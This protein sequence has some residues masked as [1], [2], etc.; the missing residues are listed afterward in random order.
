MLSPK[1]TSF[2]L[3]LQLALTAIGCSSLQPEPSQQLNPNP[4]EATFF[5][6]GLFDADLSSKLYSYPEKFVIKPAGGVTVNKMP[7]RLDKWLSMIKQENG[8]VQLKEYS[9]GS[10]KDIGLLV[11]MAVQLFDLAKEAAT[12]RPA[13]KYDA[14]VEYDKSTG[15]VRQITFYK[16]AE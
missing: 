6:S 3:A 10:T 12:Y 13:R 8:T 1:I 9:P 2:F 5:D 4:N 7:E 16:K 14:I 11:E 15:D